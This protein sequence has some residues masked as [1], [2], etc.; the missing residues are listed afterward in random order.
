[1]IKMRSELASLNHC[2]VLFLSRAGANL[3]WYY[4]SISHQSMLTFTDRFYELRARAKS[5]CCDR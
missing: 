5:T 3:Y 1:M 4:N 2:A